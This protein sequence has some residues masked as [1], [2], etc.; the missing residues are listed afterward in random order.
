MVVHHCQMRCIFCYK[1]FTNITTNATPYDYSILF[2]IRKIKRFGYEDKEAFKNGTENSFSDAAT[3]GRWNN[4]IE[5]LFE[6]EYK[7]QEGINLYRPTSF[8]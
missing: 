2:G 6:G 4:K 1:W 5:F 8:Y 7:R 3:L